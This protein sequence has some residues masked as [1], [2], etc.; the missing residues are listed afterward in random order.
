MSQ[1]DEP[2][3]GTD[4]MLENNDLPSLSIRRPILVVVM[5][6][7][8]VIAGV[9]AILAVEIREL[10]DVD[11]PIVSV[12]AEYPGASP[13]TMDAEVISLIEGAV[14][15]VSGIQSIESGSEENEGRIRIEFRPGTDLDSAS[16]DVREAVSRVSRRLPDRLEQVVVVKADDNAQAVARIAVYSETLIEEE[17][18]RI[19][20][21]DI[22][23]EL[24][25]IDGVADVQLNGDRQ[26]MLRVVVDP[27]RLAS[28]GLS[29]TD[30][31]QVL[32]LAAF[33]VPAG[34]FRSEDQQLIV[35]ADASTATAAEVSDIIIRDSIRVGYISG[36]RMRDLTHAWMGILW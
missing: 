34:S 29:V 22:I 19:V 10:P 1:P 23:P 9:A 4:A 26:R 14:A 11:R 13:E 16:S 6:L 15:R 30:V 31:S 32:R 8:I 3:R 17:V 36:R 25:S 2:V 27:L 35:R 20:E 33:D 7:L 18:T 5:N 12:R 28:Y 21:Q 24:V